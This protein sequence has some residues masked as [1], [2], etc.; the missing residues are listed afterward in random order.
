[1]NTY[2]NLISSTSILHSLFDESFCNSQKSKK[3]TDGQETKNLLSQLQ[4]PKLFHHILF[5]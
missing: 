2:L 1:M 5:F 3:I 4:H